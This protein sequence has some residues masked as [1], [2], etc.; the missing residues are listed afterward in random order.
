MCGTVAINLKA[1]FI[2]IYLGVAVQCKTTAM[3]GFFANIFITTS[4]AYFQ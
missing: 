4:K 2:S 3:K 1:N